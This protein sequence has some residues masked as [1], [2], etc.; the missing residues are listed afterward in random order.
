MKRNITDQGRPSNFDLPVATGAGI[1]AVETR[2]TASEG[3][4]CTRCDRPVRGRRRNGFCSDRCRMA[5][6]REAL[7]AKRAEAVR[8]LR[9]AVEDLEALL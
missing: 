1:D 8:S 2:T 9:R 6:R 7:E 4:P 5:K 3:Q